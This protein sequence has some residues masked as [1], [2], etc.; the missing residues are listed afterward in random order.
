MTK[1]HRKVLDVS[2]LNPVDT[3]DQEE[4]TLHALLQSGEM[5]LDTRPET[6]AKYTTL[7]KENRKQRKAISLRLPL[8]DYV[9]IKTKAAALGLP[10][11]ALI[12]SVIHQYVTGQLGL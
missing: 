6:L 2:Q 3:L 8:Q 4:K 10:Y 5:V 9:A 11:Q 1:Q 12:N 7:F